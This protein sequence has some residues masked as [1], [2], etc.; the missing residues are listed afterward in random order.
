MFGSSQICGALLTKIQPYMKEYGFKPA[1]PKN[2]WLVQ[3]NWALYKRLTTNTN[4][5]FVVLPDELLVSLLMLLFLANFLGRTMV[6]IVHI[7]IN[8]AS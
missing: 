8:T 7:H 6:L 5:T 4:F 2:A 1:S 3:N